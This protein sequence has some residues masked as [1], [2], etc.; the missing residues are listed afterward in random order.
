[1]AQVVVRIATGRP[2]HTMV[3][4]SPRRVNSE[5]AIVAVLSD[6]IDAL[7]PVTVFHYDTSA[8]NPPVAP[9]LRDPSGGRHEPTRDRRNRAPLFVPRRRLSPPGPDRCRQRAR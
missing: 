4:G 2:A 3:R 1:M 7:S 9:S 6:A 8:P 5:L